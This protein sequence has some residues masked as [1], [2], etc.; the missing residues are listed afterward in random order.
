M[1]SKQSFP[2]TPLFP[3]RI[4]LE[5]TNRCN[6]SCTFCPRHHMEY[7]VGDMNPELF[8]TLIDEL[9]EAGTR[10]LVPF[11]RGEPF[12]HRHCLELLAYAKGK[13]FTIQLATNGHMLTKEIS[14]ELVAMGVDFISFSVD[15][16]EAKEYESLRRGG[17]FETLMHNIEGLMEQ[18]KRHCSKRPCIQISA[19][20]T[21]MSQRQREGFLAFWEGKVDRIR[22]Y[23][24]H[25]QEGKFGHLDRPP[26]ERRK[27]C[28]K[29]FREM[30]IYWDGRIALCNHDWN[31]LNGPSTDAKG[32]IHVWR[33]AWYREMRRMQT[34]LDFPQGEP[35]ASCDH[36]IQYCHKG[37]LIGE[38]H[39]T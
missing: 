4:T 32:A 37:K 28:S 8:R 12:L 2:D 17:S 33:G 5:L 20:D 38:L 36:W 14:Q 13:D 10:T 23:P 34:E 6:L 24:Q 35:C 7:P 29:P 3:Q 25:S 18:R 9:S 11:F 27:P 15:A 21:G 19:V 22:I 26:E 31:R 30:V 16:V 39:E 1:S